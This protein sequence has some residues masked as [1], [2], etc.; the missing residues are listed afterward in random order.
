MTAPIDLT[1]LECDLLAAARFACA[2]IASGGIT[3]QYSDAPHRRPSSLPHGR[4]AVY[5]FFLGNTCLKVGKAGPHS[6]ARFTSHHYGFNA[7]STLARSIDQDREAIETFGRV[8]KGDRSTTL[9][10][11]QGL[12]RWIEQ[13]TSRL[14]ILLPA[15]SGPFALAFVEAFILCRLQP[16]YEGGSS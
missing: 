10:P 8:V 4:Q 14:N 16:R 6:A 2:P 15:S 5:A 7:Q 12:G 1:T 3:F 11:P 9:P 13:H